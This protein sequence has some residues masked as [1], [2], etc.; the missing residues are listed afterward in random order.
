M[1]IYSLRMTAVGKTTQ[2]QPFTAAAHL[3]YITRKDAVT[4]VMAARMPEARRQAITWLKREEREDRKNARV[5]DKLVLALPRDLSSIHHH[6]LVKALAETLTQG[7]AS[8]LAAFHTQGKDSDNPHC[9]LIL[10][11]RDAV[12][13][14]RVM[15]LSAGKKEAAERQRDGQS[16]PTTLQDIRLLWERCANAALDV[17]GRSERIDRRSLRDQGLH[18]RPQVHEGPNIQAMHRR[19][20]RPRSRDR[21]LRAN[22]FRRRGRGATRVVRYAE[23]DKGVTRVEYNLAL[24]QVGREAAPSVRSAERVAVAPP[25]LARVELNAV[26][27]YTPEP[28]APVSNLDVLPTG[29]EASPSAAPMTLPAKGPLTHPSTAT[30]TLSLTELLAVEH[31][32][33]QVAPRANSGRNRGR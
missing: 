22:P 13:K 7:R 14:R 33:A 28:L 21:L 16:A 23:I 17:A 9:H 11:D 32:T 2:K 26:A 8:W 30:H 20:V 19:G 31:G 27:N 15:F 6:A 3:K 25:L 24:K 10:R 1:A 5:I 18:R 29:S 4:H 12:T